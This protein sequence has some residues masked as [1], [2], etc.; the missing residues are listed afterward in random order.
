MQKHDRIDGVGLR[1]A[2]AQEALVDFAPASS[3]TWSRS[4][5]S[6]PT[7]GSRR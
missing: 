5:G 2:Q 7:W 3:P 1:I 6:A 4:V